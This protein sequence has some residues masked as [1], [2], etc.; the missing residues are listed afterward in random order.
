[1]PQEYL[2]PCSCGHKLRV[3]TAQAGGQLT[4]KCGRSL[5]VPTLRGLR[6]LQVAPEVAKGKVAPG[7]S[8]LHGMVFMAALLIAMAGTAIVAYHLWRC[9]Q[10]TGSG[11]TTDHS[12]HVVEHEVERIAKLTPEQALQ[13]WSDIRET[14]LGEKM[15]PIWIAA[16]DKIAQYT[17]W[18]KIGGGAV[19]AGIVVAVATLFIGRR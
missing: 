11:L 19:L 14:G 17:L 12:S 2:L 1:M 3:A 16:K 10:L 4:C 5:R 13:E 15:T 8:Q 18:M 6:E 9:A 7:W